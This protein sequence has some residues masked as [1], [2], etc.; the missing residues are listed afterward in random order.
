MTGRLPEVGFLGRTPASEVHGVLMVPEGDASDGRPY[1]V[2]SD[3]RPL[4]IP[5]AIAPGL[6]L[7]HQLKSFDRP[8]HQMADCDSYALLQMKPSHQS[9]VSYSK[10]FRSQANAYYNVRLPVQAF[11]YL[12]I[13]AFNENDIVK[14][15]LD[16]VY[17]I[18]ID[19]RNCRSS[20]LIQA[21]P[22]QTF[23]WV[24]CRLIE[25]KHQ[26]LFINRNYKFCLDAPQ[27]DSVAV[28][29]NGSEW[30]FLTPSSPIS[31]SK[32]HS[33]SGSSHHGRW[34]GKVHTGKCLGQLSVFGRLP[35]N[36]K[37]KK[38]SLENESRTIN[39]S[40]NGGY[41]GNDNANNTNTITNNNNNNEDDE[42][43]SYIK[44]LDY[45]L[46]QKEFFS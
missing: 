7:C 2:H 8:G 44:L 15:H 30:H 46:V 27:C 4:K 13:Y 22:R 31:S 18:L 21:Y 35:H 43:N 33:P 11:Y 19:A 5:F 36:N 28:V 6:K 17:R 24:Q 45:I 26:H 10:P 9:S 42:E 29:I 12:T 34:S 40:M 20:E 16:C 14:D 39:E 38:I 1:I 41:N 23:W 25:P 3:P 37:F 32:L